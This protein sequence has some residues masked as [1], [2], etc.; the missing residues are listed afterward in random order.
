PRYCPRDERSPLSAQRPSLCSVMRGVSRDAIRGV[1]AE[2]KR[3][4]AGML[5]RRRGQPAG[6]QEH[7]V[8]RRSG[9]DRRDDVRRIVR[10]LPDSSV[11]RLRFERRSRRRFVTVRTYRRAQQEY[12]AGF[13][14]RLKFS[15]SSPTAILL[16]FHGELERS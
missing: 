13:Q 6:A 9:R 3:A 11:R 2:W 10:W 16:T 15:R 8:G 4:L 14:L 12:T 1:T 5:A 7:S